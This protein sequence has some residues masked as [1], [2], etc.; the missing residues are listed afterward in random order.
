MTLSMRNIQSMRLQR[1]IEFDG[2]DDASGLIRVL[3][4]DDDREIV[5]QLENA[6]WV[7]QHKITHISSVD[8]AVRLCKHMTPKAILVALDGSTTNRVRAVPAL[9]RRLP[10][11]P[12]IGIVSPRQ[13]AEPGKFLD[14]GADALLL[15]E[16]AH[17]PTLHDLL[18]SVRRNP[19]PAAVSAR[20][21]GLE[22]TLPWRNSRMLGA[23]VCDISGSIADANL[24]LARWLGY[25]SPDEMRGRNV[26]RHILS[27]PDDWSNW[28]QV[29]GDTRAL[30]HHRTSIVSLNGQQLWVEL[31]VFAAPRHPSHLQ[32]VFMDRSEMALPVDQSLCRDNGQ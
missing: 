8:D 26:P 29:A 6:L 5:D 9:R 17:R 32:A 10:S 27:D 14:Q 15:R 12:V 23:L 4:I 13:Y 7:W 25:P 21:D 30:L 20:N 2:A 31:E 22:L 19:A 1:S 24:M 28:V 3:V 16:D 18:M 11:V